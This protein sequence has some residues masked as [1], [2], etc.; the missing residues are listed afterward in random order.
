MTAFTIPPTAS[1]KTFA[2]YLRATRRRC[3]AERFMV[4]EA[5]ERIK[6]HF[7]VADV[8]EV[9]QTEGIHVARA[10]VYATIDCLVDCGLLRPLH[11]DASP[12]RY[13]ASPSSHNHLVC[14]QCGKVKDM[15]DREL[16]DMLR[17]RRYS[18]FR[19]SYFTLS[20]FGICSACARR[21]RKAE[22]ENRNKSKSVIS[23]KKK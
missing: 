6:G 19:P 4:L 1:A 14:L 5:A 2:A 21:R 23:S 7:T 17:S 8:S 12:V 10:T 3:T 15:H 16:E 9:L 13:E 22:K 18:A 20:V 11:I